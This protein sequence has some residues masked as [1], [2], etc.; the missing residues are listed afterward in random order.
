MSD[1]EVQV[2]A[3]GSFVE[4]IA[5]DHSPNTVSAVFRYPNLDVASAF[6]VSGRYQAIIP[7][8]E[9]GCEIEVA[10]FDEH[11]DRASSKKLVENETLP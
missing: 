4:T 6:F 1:F 7:L 8:R 2:V 9:R 5:G 10:L 11:E 3:R